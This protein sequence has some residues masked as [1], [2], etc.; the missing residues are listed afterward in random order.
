MRLLALLFW[1]TAFYVV[2]CTL[3]IIG[4][5]S[6]GLPSGTGLSAIV[7]TVWVCSLLLVVGGIGVM[8]RRAF[9]WKTA[10]PGA[11][12]L[13]VLGVA[14]IGGALLRFSQIENLGLLV[15]LLV[16]PVGLS[17]ASL[18]AGIYVRRTAA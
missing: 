1:T 6:S 9:G 3:Y 5:V 15:I 17:A 13:L 14:L 4:A 2:G 11:G 7:V 10:V 18:W 16:V 12:V 8:F